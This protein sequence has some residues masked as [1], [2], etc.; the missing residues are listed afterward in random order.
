MLI[1]VIIWIL[2]NFFAH[3]ADVPRLE[4]PNLLEQGLYSTDD[5]TTTTRTSFI[6]NPLGNGLPKWAPVA[7]FIPA[8]LATIL[9]FMDQQITALI[10][11][12]KDHKLKVS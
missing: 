3:V 9:L 8:L 7:A 2:V 1:S 4:V 10:I 11:N 12:R 6:I 5:N